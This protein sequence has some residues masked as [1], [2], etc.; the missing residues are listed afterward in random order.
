MV[1][2][3]TIQGNHIQTHKTT[4]MAADDQQYVGI[5]RVVG[6]LYQGGERQVMVCE[7]FPKVSRG[8]YTSSVPSGHIS[9][10]DHLGDMEIMIIMIMI[11]K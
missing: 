5:T 8:K 4:Y 11:Y 2:T 6:Y 1:M 3:E 9:S 10:H 7:R